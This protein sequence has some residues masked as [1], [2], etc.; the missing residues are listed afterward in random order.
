MV[1]GHR[2]QCAQSFV[3][4]EHPI[5]GTLQRSSVFLDV[6]FNHRVQI[7][8]RLQKIPMVARMTGQHGKIRENAPIAEHN[9]L[10]HMADILHA[11]EI[12]LDSRQSFH[13]ER[14]P[15]NLFGKRSHQITAPVQHQRNHLAIYVLGKTAMMPGG[16]GQHSHGRLTPIFTMAHRKSVAYCHAHH[17]Q[18]V[19]HQTHKGQILDHRF[20]S[21]GIFSCTGCPCP[22]SCTIPSLVKMRY[23]ASDIVFGANRHITLCLLF[24][25][26]ISICKQRMSQL[27]SQCFQ[28]FRPQQN[29]NG[30]FGAGGNILYKAARPFRRIILSLFQHSLQSFTVCKPQPADISLDSSTRRNDLDGQTGHPTALYRP[31]VFLTDTGSLNIFYQY[32]LFAIHHRFYGQSKVLGQTAKKDESIIIGNIQPAAALHLQRR[33]RACC[34]IQLDCGKCPSLADAANCAIQHLH[35]IFIQYT[36]ARVRVVR[37][38]CP[39]IEKRFYDCFRFID[40]N[41]SHTAF[42]LFV[43]VFFK[44][45]QAQVSRRLP[46][47]RASRPRLL[48][49]I[50]KLWK[51]G[52]HPPGS[53]FR[54]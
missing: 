2:V 14:I 38:R 46:I 31:G 49:F 23:K 29:P 6:I 35:L 4:S 37:L 5:S 13:G 54:R 16:S 43:H 33:Q 3:K 19:F 8:L 40:R 26:C 39:S 34:F 41:N 44:K 11:P 12:R 10:V 18:I 30:G 32:L 48:L 45:G 1:L 53:G 47:S 36:I 15:D 52:I 17:F 20:Q 50:F 21:A 28:F 22:I 24:F 42:S 7:F 51:P 25:L 9:S 27:F